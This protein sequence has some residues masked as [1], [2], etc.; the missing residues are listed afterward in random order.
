MMVAGKKEERGEGGFN[1]ELR[2]LENNKKE[3]KCSFILKDTN[4]AFANA[5]RRNIINKVPVMAIE[6][7]EFRK[8]SSILYDEMI[9]HRLGLIPLTTDLKGYNLPSECSCKGKLCAKCKIKLILKAKGPCTVY[10][11]DLKSRDPKIKPVY[12]KMPIVKLLKNQTL[13]LEAT[14]VLGEGKEHIKWSPGLAYYK[15]KPIIEIGKYKDA[16]IIA[17][18]CPVDV[19]DVK[20]NKLTINKDN[21]L[22]CHLCNACKDIDSGIEVR[23]S[24]S[25]IVFNVESFGQLDCEEILL[26]AVDIFDKQLSELQKKIK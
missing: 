3:N 8:N 11:S 7:V 19:F 20:D 1:M 22:K 6:D 18:V 15:Y 21:Y 25:E 16:A 9:A 24:E 2:I 26:K 14:A 4:A 13:E 10:A 12:P 17:K 23:E 5:L